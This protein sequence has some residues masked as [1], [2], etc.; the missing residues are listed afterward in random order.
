MS[1][2][3]QIKSVYGNE[4]IYPVCDKAKAFAAIAGDKTLTRTTIKLVKELGYAVNVQQGPA[5]L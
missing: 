2:T 1:I 3:V 5:A 4:T